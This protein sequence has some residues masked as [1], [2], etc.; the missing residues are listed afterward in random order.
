MRTLQQT[1]DAVI[2]SMKRQ[3]SPS[4]DLRLEVPGS[5]MFVCRYRSA[6]GRKCAVGCLIPDEIYSQMMENRGPLKSDQGM[7][8]M[9]RDLGYDVELLS[10]LQL[11]H[12]SSVNYGYGAVWLKEFLE[13]A[14]V[15]A[16]QFDLDGSSCVLKGNDDTHCTS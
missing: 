16:T 7:A 8:K 15:V 2:D 3:G 12:D 10:Q 6:G 4:A 13:R 9:M 14:H 5:E 11:A 1:F